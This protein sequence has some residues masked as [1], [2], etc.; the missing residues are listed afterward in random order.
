MALVNPEEPSV[1]F[2]TIRRIPMYI[3]VLNRFI[4]GEV[5]WISTTDFANEL[6]IKPIQ[7]RK[8]L[9]YSGIIGKPKRGYPVIE[10]NDTLQKFLGWN[11][12]LDAVLVGTGALG[13]AL[14]GYSGIAENGLRIVAAFDADPQLTN[15]KI[16]GIKVQPVDKLESVIRKMNIE[17]GIITVPK[18]AAQ[19]VADAFVAAG[20]RGIWNF[21]PVTIKVP[22]SVIVQRED[23]SS[24]LAVL[25][26][27]LKQSG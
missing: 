3:N 23:L 19:R 9:A 20:I 16:H 10:L 11:K 7:V 24:G 21:S 1:P 26:M 25:T 8:D 4:E 27:R 13:S 18:V 17:I 6:N 15:R 2:P 14:L 5:E 12:L 22:P